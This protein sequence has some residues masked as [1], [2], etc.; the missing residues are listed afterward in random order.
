MD[1]FLV[2]TN[3]KPKTDSRFLFCIMVWLTE[4]NQ[5]KTSTLSSRLLGMVFFEN[6]VS[7]A[8]IIPTNFQEE[9]HNQEKGRWMGA[10][11]EEIQS[12]HKNQIWELVE[13]P[14]G[15]RL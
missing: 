13:L 3:N 2:Y 11:E 9:V 4:P 14:K 6:L 7:Y 5:V 15:N 1:R 12:L 10:I 8:L